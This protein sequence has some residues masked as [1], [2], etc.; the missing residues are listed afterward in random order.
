MVY[1]EE[2]RGDRDELVDVTA[3]ILVE[4]YFD[5]LRFQCITPVRDWLER[6]DELA[7]FLGG[8]IR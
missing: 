3:A 5:D 7:C 6:L 8:M 1:V 2:S 4:Y